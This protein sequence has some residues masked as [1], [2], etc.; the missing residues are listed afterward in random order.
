MASLSKI[1]KA[2]RAYHGSPHDFDKFS[3]DKIG[4]GEGA[5]AYGHGLYFA[6]KEDVARGYRDRLSDARYEIPDEAKVAERYGEDVLS[7]LNSTY[8]DP[9]E[10]AAN[11]DHLRNM[12]QR[13]LRLI[14]ASSL[15]DV[16]PAYEGDFPWTILDTAK[17]LDNLDA[18]LKSD[19]IKLTGQGRMYEV[20]IHADPDSLLDWDKP[21]SAQPKR[22]QEFLGDTLSTTGTFSGLIPPPP[23][24]PGSRLYRQLGAQ[25]KMSFG[26]S[27]QELDTPIPGAD[28]AASARLR[29]AGIPGPRYLDGMSRSAGDGTHNYVTFDDSIVDI[30]RKYEEGGEVE[31]AEG[32]RVGALS[33]MAKKL[34]KGGADKMVGDADTARAVEDLAEELSAAPI[35]G[36][37]P[38]SRFANEIRAEP[39]KPVMTGSLDATKNIP[40]T[41]DGK[42]PHEWSPED[43]QRFGDHYGVPNMGPL[44]PPQTITDR[45][46]RTFEIPGGFD[47]KF[48]YYD[49][50]HMKAQGMNA[51]ELDEALH[52]KL[53]RKLADS[54]RAPEGD[55][56]QT[57]SNLI[58][59]LTSPNNPLFP[60]QVAMSRLR[61]SDPASL[62]K[63]A[64]YLQWEPGQEVAKEVRDAVNDA[65]KRDYGL[66][67]AE[68]GG[69]G[70]SGIA[71]Y[72]DAAE[73]A[74]MFRKNPE[75]FNK[76]PDE[77]WD[78]LAERVAAQ[79]RG[80][81]GK[82]SSFGV[83]FQDPL[84]ANISAMDRHM[85]T[86]AGPERILGSKE[87]AD[88][89]M[90][91]AMR[92]YNSS[93]PGGGVNRPEDLPQAFVQD[94][95]LEQLGRHSRL[96]MNV[97]KGGETIRNP[98]LP[99]RMRD[100]QWIYEPE[101]SFT[102]SDNYRR[103][104]EVNAEHA[105]QHGLGL[106][107]SQWMQW[108][109]QRR[110]VEP[111]ENMFPGTER[112]PRMS[113]DQLRMVD[114][115]HRE[116]G[117]KDYTKVNV[118]K[119]TGD[120]RLKPTRPISNP[121]RLGYF[122]ISPLAAAA[123]LSGHRSEEDDR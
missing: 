119:E 49:L 100:E 50:L 102:F 65:I 2:I 112:V 105:N 99:D 69:L 75:W 11:A 60:N 27:P 74:A 53:Q 47:G 107:P 91:N 84:N 20:D 40:V 8:G 28:A 13:N 33:K 118:D 31:M 92:R 10:I 14:G 110:R 25:E 48:T 104:L 55:R 61:S 95:L 113:T 76:R 71:N 73:L 3:M 41:M 111:H 116:A 21:F 17:R 77:G 38:L 18:L 80:L 90:L 51:D 9:K 66:G 23:S 96:K 37:S 1:L 12:V 24:R 93:K 36:A 81:S 16:K 122:T 30:K 79:V 86:I 114:D 19:D 109:R 15:S 22:V 117:F 97:T 72:S 39:G 103:G 42:H 83:V 108:D 32:G 120:Y 123:A 88:E 82:T 44:T 98:D 78:D 62:D 70:V 5:Q 67:A 58:F 4:T 52:A 121:S 7:M 54:V 64:G 56:G 63:L 34:I 57:W 29:E 115:A 26:R 35:T 68:K 85:A 59:G 101:K 87:A 106:F 89:F 46:G 43:W 94:L 45:Q 6:G